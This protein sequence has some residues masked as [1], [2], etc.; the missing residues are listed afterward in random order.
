MSNKVLEY[1]I[2]AKDVTKAAVESASANVRKFGSAVRS[3]LG[4]V[5]DMWGSAASG[6]SGFAKSVFANA[7]NIRSSIQM[8][9]ST[10]RSALG[11]MR[12]AFA[13]E[14]MTVQFKTLIGS[15]DEARAHMAMLQR[16][17]DTPPFSLEEFAAASRSM[18]VMSDGALGFERSLNIVGDAAAATG[19]PLET[20]AHA[21]GR[22]YAVIRDGQPISR[23]TMEL[24]NMGVITPATADKLDKMQQAGADNI[25]IWNELEAALGK[26]HGAMEETEGTADGLMGAISSQW[27]NTVRSFGGA[28]MD[29]AK[30]GLGALLAKLR[31]LNENGVIEDWGGKVARAA[32]KAVEILKQAAGLFGKVKAAYDWIKDQAEIGGGAVGGA[33]GYLMGGGRDLKGMLVA[34]R[35]S[36]FDSIEEQISRRE[37]AVKREEEIRD[38]AQSKRI[39]VQEGSVRKEAAERAKIAEQMEKARE[40]AAKKDAEAME[41]ARKKALAERT[42]YER[43]ALAGYRADADKARDELTAA[44]EASARAMGW[45]RDPDALRAHEREARADARMERRLERDTAKLDKMFGSEWR[46]ENFS[47]RLN[48]RLRSAREVVLA[49][50]AEK[51]AAQKLDKALGIVDDCEKH[52]AELVKGE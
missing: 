44:R 35:D 17:G 22:A 27:D 5:R 48:G 28:F 46:G 9:A 3:A 24:K 51:A 13:F 38:K 21:V 50:E 14:K 31:E 16:M 19:Q 11:N 41:A 43:S 37:D 29:V 7:T 36:G 18:M 12:K 8:V 6:V 42:D 23:A 30:E 47:G 45:Y 49:R 32:G 10:V 20:L 33:I 2:K 25:A 40:D 39:A 34:A 26:F 15:M 1:I 4:K 52:L